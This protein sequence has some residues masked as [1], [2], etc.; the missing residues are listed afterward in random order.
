[1]TDLRKLLQ[2]ELA[3]GKLSQL[4]YRSLQSRIKND[5]PE[6]LQGYDT[7][8]IAN[9][10]EDMLN[11]YALYLYNYIYSYKPEATNVDPS[12]DPN[13]MHVGPMAQDIEKV[14]P[15][16]VKET[17]S[18]V[19]VVDGDRLA[20]VNAGTLGELARRMIRLEKLLGVYDN[21]K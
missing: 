10:S 6:E 15:D 17:E 20:L 1:M 2:D 7:E 11:N 13:E 21:E 9:W 4:G 18:G 16:C 12:I 8:D 5:A 19:K 14:A 3:A